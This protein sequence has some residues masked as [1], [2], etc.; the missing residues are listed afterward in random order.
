M[1]YNELKIVPFFACHKSS[2]WWRLVVICIHTRA[3][4]ECQLTTIQMKHFYCIICKLFFWAIPLCLRQRKKSFSNLCSLKLNWKCRFVCHFA[5]FE[6]A[7]NITHLL[8]TVS[9]AQFRLFNSSMVRAYVL[10]F[11]FWNYCFIVLGAAPKIVNGC[12]TNSGFLKKNNLF[13]SKNCFEII[14]SCV[15][16]SYYPWW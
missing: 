2:M 14:Y 9:N 6:S 12:K 13:F 1:I 11:F 16:C 15:F 4:T 8:Q 7:N 5:E 10:L 3:H